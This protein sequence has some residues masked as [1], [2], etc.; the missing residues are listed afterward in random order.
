MYEKRNNAK[1]KNTYTILENKYEDDDEQV[2]EDG[3]DN[4]TIM[5]DLTL[6]MTNSNRG[7]MS[8]A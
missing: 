2:N 1:D 3:E 7:V 4:R 8:P 5:S 6:K